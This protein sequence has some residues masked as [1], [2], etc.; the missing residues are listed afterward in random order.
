MNNSF[1]TPVTL[2]SES[3]RRKWKGIILS[4]LREKPFN[5][6]ELKIYNNNYIQ[7]QGKYFICYIDRSTKKV[8]SRKQVILEDVRQKWQY[9]IIRYLESQWIPQTDKVYIKQEPIDT[10][11]TD[12]NSIVTSPDIEEIKIGYED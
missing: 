4:I 5:Q 10:E 6:H 9:H 2:G 1:S 7:E 3:N 12:P 8:I 11:L